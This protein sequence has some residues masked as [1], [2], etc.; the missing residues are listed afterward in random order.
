MPALP[1]SH[2]RQ[3]RLAKMPPLVPTAADAPP[4]AVTATRDRRAACRVRVRAW[5]TL[6]RPRP[7]PLHPSCCC[8]PSWQRRLPPTR[9]G[10]TRQPRC[11]CPA[12]AYAAT[13]HPAA[14]DAQWGVGIG[15][16]DWASLG[17]YWANVVGHLGCRWEFGGR[18]EI[19]VFSC[20]DR[21]YGLSVR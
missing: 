14:A 7:C 4:V 16:E 19:H 18:T 2:R 13:L 1:R 20:A 6:L 12:A 17:C 15:V 11:C 3:S 9:V 21:F 5:A 8:A 10:A